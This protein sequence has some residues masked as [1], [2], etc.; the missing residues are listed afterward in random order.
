MAAGAALGIADRR[1]PGGAWPCRAEPGRRPPRPGGERSRAAARVRDPGTRHHAAGR[2][3]RIVGR[4]ARPAHRPD[5]RPL[6]RS[7]DEILSSRSARRTYPSSV[8]TTGRTPRGHCPGEGS[9][10]EPQ[11][12]SRRP[13]VVPAAAGR[14]ARETPAAR[15]GRRRR[16][17]RLG[18]P[19]LLKTRRDTHHPP[20]PDR[21]AATLLTLH[22]RVVTAA[23][24]DR[25]ALC[26]PRPGALPEAGPAAA[27]ARP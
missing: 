14:H 8:R 3:R 27:S 21:L 10:R 1:D 11:H 5:V 17:A 23:V 6:R 26:A 24:P 12:R 20:D 19:N 4:F 2:L 9:P 15:G 7:C 16:E 25:G 18:G 13:H 22:P